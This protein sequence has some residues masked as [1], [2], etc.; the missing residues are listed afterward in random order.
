MSAAAEEP[1]V[2]GPAEERQA[3]AGD[4]YA[5][6]L[7]GAAAAWLMLGGWHLQ[8]RSLLGFG[9]AAWMLALAGVLG[10]V[11][12]GALLI[13]PLLGRIGAPH[14]AFAAMH[15]V[16][17]LQAVYAHDLFETLRGALAAG[18]APAAAV[19][20]LLAFA[21]VLPGLLLAG[22]AQAAFVP[23]ITRG[24]GDPAGPLRRHW[25]IL[26]LGCAAGE[27][28]RVFMEIR[29]GV[30]GAWQAA[31]AAA[32][33][34][35]L[36]A[37]ALRHRYPEVS[38][39]A[40]ARPAAGERAPAALWLL[41]GGLALVFGAW[42]AAAHRMAVL[43][44]GAT[45]RVDASLLAALL[46]ALFAGG[47]FLG[48]GAAGAARRAA[49]PRHLAVAA[50]AAAAALHAY[51]PL[52]ALLPALPRALWATP[53][54]LSFEID[55]YLPYVAACFALLLALVGLP[56][57]L[58]ARTLPLLTRELWDRH[59]EGAFAVV[60]AAV[61]AGL[62]AGIALARFVL[63]PQLGLALAL[64]ATPLLLLALLLALARR[65]RLV[66]AA[67]AA[68]VL[69]AFA[70]PFFDP[71]LLLSAPYSGRPQ[72]VEAE[73]AYLRQGA[74]A[75]L[76]SRTLRY[77]FEISERGLPKVVAAPSPEHG[78]I[79]TD[80]Q[81]ETLAGM[82]PLLYRPAAARAAVIGAGTGRVAETLLLGA[83]MEEV[84]LAEPDRG[85]L[86]LARSL[87]LSRAAFADG[88]LRL[89]AVDPRQ[90]LLRSEPASYDAIAVAATVPGLGAGA[91][92][93]A[94]EFY[95]LAAGRLTEQGV[96]V[97]HFA[98]EE[99]S[100]EL[101]AAVAKAAGAAFADYRVFVPQPEDVLLV[102][103]RDPAAIRLLRA[104]SF[105]RLREPSGAARMGLPNVFAVESALAFER[106][107][108]EPL[109]D[110]Y[111]D[112]YPSADLFPGAGWL[113]DR[114]LF[115]GQGNGWLRG[116]LSS[117]GFL[118][119]QPEFT[120]AAL[121]APRIAQLE[122]NP[123]SEQQS[124]AALA[125]PALDPA[126][127][128]PEAFAR[129]AAARG[130]DLGQ[131]AALFEPDCAAGPSLFERASWLA[132]MINAIEP[133]LHAAERQPLRAR[134]QDGLPCYA[135][136]LADPDAGRLAGI[137]DAW[138]AGDHQ[139][140]REAGVPLLYSVEDFTVDADA[141]IL[142]RLALAEFAAGEPDNV[143]RMSHQLGT[144]ASPAAR[145]AL[146]V[147]YAH[148]L[149]SV[150]EEVDPPPEEEPGDGR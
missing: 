28:L 27:A 41:P 105:A 93:H 25:Q 123:R 1:P 145:F 104:G 146:R 43:A 114:D 31:A 113:L 26:L 149:R 91:A 38:L 95:E 87:P 94:M 86:A 99:L 12:L 39:A 11:A 78:R 64:A 60:L 144:R 107:A 108:I 124:W 106:R 129:V 51:E 61:L 79:A 16:L 122:V 139:R 40:P 50:L 9:A 34:A 47:L 37:W 89:R 77:G 46:L 44:F 143:I 130:F 24:R 13:R 4:A 142:L 75:A 19:Q 10:G 102:A 80:L 14:V 55:P 35:G 63:L 72:P 7:P 127:E 137:Y 101:F 29:F 73:I 69:A 88:R 109:L 120:T 56:A 83:A 42:A 5:A 119:R 66:L 22:A 85:A 49:L 81:A 92:L 90:L 112:V 17:A 2:R 136:L 111:V 96:F 132:E 118:F 82:I 128:L 68:A 59:G 140:V 116:A 148:G 150:F 48:Q 21:L 58:A 70:K 103:A 3:L 45:P 15:A 138:L 147:I 71:A 76:A 115:M 32:G 97:Q 8:L 54:F 6:L 18:A 131:V 36:V 65:R 23:V 30:L 133:F 33:L 53:L 126:A 141:S 84:E 67:A 134:L 135:A 100:P 117:F 125:L 98:A 52:L 74:A 20:W 121:H 57:A 110:T 62:A